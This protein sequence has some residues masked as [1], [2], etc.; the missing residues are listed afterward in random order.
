MKITKIEQSGST[1]TLNWAIANNADI[2]TDNALVSVI[3][4]EL[5]YWITI[6]DINAFQL[7][8]LTQA[9]RNK[10][11]ILEVLPIEIPSDESLKEL[12]CGTVKVNDEELSTLDIA[13]VPMQLFNNISMQ[14][15][16]DNDIIDPSVVH[17]FIPMMLRRYTIKIPYNFSDIVYSLNIDNHSC[18]K[19]FNNNYPNTL[20]DIFTID[21]MLENIILMNVISLTRI[22][23]YPSHLEDILNVT[24]YF[25]IKKSDKFIDCQLL[26]YKK[27]HPISKDEIVCNLFKLD[28]ESYQ[29]SMDKMRNINSPLDVEFVIQL[30]IVHMQLLQN[31]FSNNE[32]EIK[33]ESS[34][35][36]IIKSGLSYN[37]FRIPHN[38][39]TSGSVKIEGYKTRLQEAELTLMN[40][41]N[42]LSSADKTLVDNSSIFALLPGIY[43][44]KAVVTYHTD[45]MDEYEEAIA[46]SDFNIQHLMNNMQSIANS[47]IK[48]LY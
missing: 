26:S 20:N 46:F 19:I 41:I 36:D 10:L 45:K 23:R 31:T 9:Y 35:S 8:R 7:F 2:K 17:L 29:A 13:K 33:Y 21:P 6:S 12:F 37:D 30:P 24:K 18:E 25:P 32:L 44:T 47:L 43:K 16:A 5:F 15:K 28:K 1:N 3:N 14:M 42:A 39:E 48:Q 22:I 34:M 11:K 38:N 27:T 4:N 40:S